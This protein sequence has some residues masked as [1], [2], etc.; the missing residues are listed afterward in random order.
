MPEEKE[1]PDWRKRFLANR[2]SFESLLFEKELVA[3]KKEKL[4]AGLLGAAGIAFLGSLLLAV[5]ILRHKYFFSAADAAAF[6]TVQAFLEQ[7]KAGGIWSIFKPFSLGAAHPAALPLYYLTYVPV[8]KYI[9]ADLYRA[10]VLVNSF[11]LSTLV[12]AVFMAV[13]KNR[14]NL[15]GW[16][17]AT[18]AVSLP[19]VLETARHPD[20]GLAAMALAAGLYCCYINSNEFDQP[21]WNVWFGLTLSLGFFTDDM[22]WIYALPLLPFLTTACVGGL[23]LNSLL[24][25]LL[26]GLILNLPWYAY[27]FAFRALNH[28][29]GAAGE[30]VWRPGVW[31]YF[32]TMAGA[33]GLPMFI[34]G[35]LALLWMYYS[36][37]MPYSPR[38]IVAAWFWVPFLICYFFFGDRPRLMYPALLPIALAI[39]VMAP[40]Q[41]RKYILGIAAALL[42][43]NQSGLV[44]PV[45]AGRSTAVFGLPR[46][47]EKGVYRIEES[48]DAIR[49]RAGGLKSSAVVLIGE[50]KNIDYPSFNHVAAQSAGRRAEGGRPE[51]N[52]VR[53]QAQLLGLADFVVHR[54]G[55]FGERRNAPD[56]REL[57]K[58]IFKPWF[59][60]VFTLVSAFELPDT[61]KLVIY[62]KNKI[63]E[64]PF[65]EGVHKLKNCRIAGF[66]LEDGDLELFGFDPA[67]GAY[68][69]AVFSAPQAVFADGLDVYGLQLEIENFLPFSD[70]GGL[71][72]LRPIKMSKA[73]I[74]RLK[75]NMRAFERYLSSRYSKLQ[76]VEVDFDGDL[77]ISGDYNGRGFYWI[78]ALNEH[79]PVIELRNA[80]VTPLPGWL[81]WLNWNIAL[82]AYT[83]VIDLKNRG[84]INGVLKAPDFL[85]RFFNFSYDISQRPYYITFDG[86][87]RKKRLLEISGKPH[88]L[89]QA[90]HPKRAAEKAKPE[91]LY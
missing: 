80:A 22:F 51:L 16:L 87:K 77:K 63:T 21:N 11:Y 28:Y 37:F 30:H 20:P 9:T 62:E 54:T 27:I 15:S 73:R 8:L 83:P 41:V 34:L 47:A 13:K 23:A 59:L 46:P 36:V 57:E 56:S 50:D 5:W 72:K 26:P 70:T 48:L 10:L 67:R 43:V 17:G 12:F 40:N 61:S 81:N 69:L 85:L 52:F 6:N 66:T 19:F 38:K 89:F 42:L 14:N 35:A 86:T 53:Y 90:A 76:N 32:C 29:S 49:L 1:I 64:R 44:S 39:A 45:F 91:V 31:N 25:G 65:A 84:F 79:P 4:Y 78:A 55:A 33:A 68:A 2:M 24:K 82:D 3:P 18:V 71:S 58:E 60:K 7:Y 88:S 74:T 75:T